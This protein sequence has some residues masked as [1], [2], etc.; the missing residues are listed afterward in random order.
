MSADNDKTTLGLAPISDADAES[1]LLSACFLDGGPAIRQCLDN[2][3][4]PEAFDNRANRVIFSCLSQIFLAGQTPTP[5]I[6]FAELRGTNQLEAVGGAA[7]VM[8]VSELVSTTVSLGYF[9]DRVLSLYLKRRFTD[10]A[11]QAIESFHA[12]TSAAEVLASLDALRADSAFASATLRERLA[13]ALLNPDAEPAEARTV[14]S[15]KGIPIATPGN[16]C[17]LYGQSKAGKGALAYAM[18]G[19]AM[20]NGHA[21]DFLGAGSSNPQGHALVHFDSEQS[22]RQHWANLQTALKRA[23]LAKAPPWLRSY[24]VKGWTVA[25]RRQ[26]IEPALRQARSEC[27]GIHSLILDGAADFVLDPNDSGECFPFV[28]ELGAL[29]ENF[30]M[31][32]VAIVHQN[33]GNADKGRGHLGSQLERRAESNLVVEKDANGKS[34]IYSTKQRGA[35]ILKADGPCFRWDDKEGM[36]VSTE[37]VRVE[38]DTAA[39][40][41]ARELAQEVFADH[42]GLTF[43]AL[44]KAIQTTLKCSEA[45]AERR[46]AEMRKHKVIGHFPGNLLALIK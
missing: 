35:P 8:Q 14:Y 1:Y 4:K 22:S 18:M 21:G 23:G 15:L 25:E 43:S 36:H 46:I 32:A 27:G 3:L 44:S 33:P 29:A 12:G 17:A 37:T 30:D 20:A 31:P 38:R 16:L 28:D 7:Y 45:T 10:R 6:L 11:Q 2:G 41:R 19:A 39:A 24:H 13:A 9:L 34:V 40:E 42:G 26:S 5:E